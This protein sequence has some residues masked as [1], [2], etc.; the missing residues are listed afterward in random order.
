MT[1]FKQRQSNNKIKT[2]ILLTFMFVLL[3]GV[4]ASVAQYMGM[5]GSTVLFPIVVCI[6]LASVWGS[7]WWSDKLVLKL[8]KAK[9]IEHDDNPVLYNVVSEIAVAAGLPTP[10]I[11][12]VEDSAPNAFATGRNPQHAIIAFTTGI[13]EKMNRDELQ[14][15]AAHEMS[16]IANRDTLLMAVAATTAGIIALVG[17]MFWRIAFLGGGRKSK[18]GSGYLMLLAVVALIIAPIAAMLLRFALSRS[19]ESLADASAVA[20][21]RNPTGLRNALLKLQADSTVV[22]A[23]STATAHLWIESPLDG[24]MG[25]L[26]S[27]HPPIQERIDALDAM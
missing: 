16:H 22:H 10:K 21:T 3:A 17:D 5:A 6:A 20:F 1:S 25:K 13:L 2:F 14:G 27:T 24:K 9:L 11:A 7:Y 18:N 26:F 4:F 23:H 15:V 12:I 8:T 19:R